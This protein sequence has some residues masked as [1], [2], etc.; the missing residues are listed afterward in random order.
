MRVF[1]E[2]DRVLA[3]A[4][5]ENL[6]LTISELL[7]NESLR[8]SEFPAA[9]NQIYLAHAAVS[10]L[11]KRV[12]ERMSA[13][14]TESQCSDQEVA[15]GDAVEE[16]RRS[17]ARLLQVRPEEVAFNGRHQQFVEPNCSGLPLP[18]GRQRRDLSRRLSFQRLPVDVL[19]IEGRRSQ[20]HPSSPFRRDRCRKMS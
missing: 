19:G 9:R 8:L 20:I 14:L 10:P 16:T 17:L 7:A 4:R 6:M 18:T 11:P 3:E 2:S 13:Y 5:K 15:A 12:A 1:F